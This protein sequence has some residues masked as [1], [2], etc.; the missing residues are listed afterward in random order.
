[1]WKKN[2]SNS[3]LSWDCASQFFSEFRVKLY[4]RWQISC[5][6]VSKAICHETNNN[7]AMGW[8][9]EWNNCQQL[10]AENVSSLIILRMFQ[11]GAHCSLRDRRSTKVPSNETEGEN[12]LSKRTPTRPLSKKFFSCYSIVSNNMLGVGFI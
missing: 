10:W 6:T 1:M 3:Y 11:N 12:Q 2:S 9:K 7:D 4:W 5:C 8:T